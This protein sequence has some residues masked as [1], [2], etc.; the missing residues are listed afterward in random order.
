MP[1]FD[2]ASPS[3]SRARRGVARPRTASARRREGVRA[4]DAKRKKRKK[5]KK[6]KKKKK[7]NKKAKKEIESDSSLIDRICCIG[8]SN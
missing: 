7:A 6:K 8:D 4:S 1:A 3:P 5:K 2:E